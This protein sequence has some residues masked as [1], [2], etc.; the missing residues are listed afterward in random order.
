MAGGA[1]LSKSS[2]QRPVGPEKSGPAGFLC[3]GRPEVAVLTEYLTRLFIKNHQRVEDPDVRLAYGLL[4]AWISIGVNLFLAVLMVGAGILLN[5]I[6]LMANAAHT[7]ADIVTSVAVLIGFKASRLP[8][9]KEHPHGHGRAEDIA[10]LVIAILLIIVGY[11]FFAR[12]VGRLMRPETVKGSAAVVVGLL[13]AAVIKEWLA[14]FSITLGRRVNSSALT[15]D[16]WHH[17]SDAI[18]MALVSI[19]IIASGAGY[20]RADSVLGAGVAVLIAYTG[21]RLASGTSSRLLGE[22]PSDEMVERIASI[23]RATEGV[24]GTHKVSVHDYGGNT[25][26]SLHIQ[27]DPNLPVR[28][29]HEIAARVKYRIAQELNADT[30]VHVEPHQP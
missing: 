13:L 22:K 20:S 9:D 3:A 7:A 25:K 16:A 10:S 26:I 24:L 1:G 27:V 8:A 28:E 21:Y 30:T 14:R 2:R 23:T 11:E 17:R 15:A 18:S 5:S 12:S 29:S 4:E 19:G 6:A